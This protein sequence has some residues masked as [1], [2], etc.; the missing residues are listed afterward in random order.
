M[1]YSDYMQ[2]WNLLFGGAFTIILRLGRL[3]SN[4][5]LFRI[6]RHVWWS[7]WIFEPYLMRELTNWSRWW[8][9]RFNLPSASDAP[10]GRG[11]HLIPILSSALDLLS[12]LWTTNARS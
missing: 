9:L 4:L 8:L 3:W 2:V 7:E 10:Q 1:V 12:L 11:E 6:L 5:H